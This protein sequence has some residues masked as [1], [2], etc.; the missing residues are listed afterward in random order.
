MCGRYP[1]AGVYVLNLRLHARDQIGWLEAS[2]GAAR[3]LHDR[4]M[5]GV[6]LGNL[7]IAYKNLGETRRAIEFHEQ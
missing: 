2:V 5:V 4:A 3:R 6:A 1:D 7:G